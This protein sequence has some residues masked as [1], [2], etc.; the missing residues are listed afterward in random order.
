MKASTYEK[1]RRA[2]EDFRDMCRNNVL[3]SSSEFASTRNIDRGFTKHLER[4]GF[5]LRRGHQQYQWTGKPITED[6]VAEL[7]EHR[8]TEARSTVTPT[9]AAND[10]QPVQQS[11]GF[12]QPE[13]VPQ[14]VK[15]LERRIAA[16]EQLMI[17]KGVA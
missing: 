15:D 10:T 1:Y 11:L 6:T 8:R 13:P 7:A 12:A 2:M 4:A 3:I 16:L 9:D 5:V 17:R 14:Y